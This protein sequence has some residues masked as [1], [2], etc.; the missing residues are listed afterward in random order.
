MEIDTYNEIMGYMPRERTLF[1]YCRDRYALQLL[2]YA[3]GG[4]A[5][6]GELR[7]GPF[8]SLLEKPAVRRLLA[9]RGDGW[10]DR[11]TLAAAWPEPG[12]TF[13]LT[14]GRWGGDSRRWQQTSRPGYNLVLRLNF[15][16]GHDRRYRTLVNPERWHPFR[17]YCHPMLMPGER[18]YMRETLAW[19]RIDLDLDRGEALIEEIQSD[20]VR[21]AARMAAR[22]DGGAQLPRRWLWQPDP[23]QVREYVAQVLAPYGAIW[24]QAMLSAA[25]GFIREELGLSRIWYHSWEG[26]CALKRISPE[27]APPRSLYTQLPQR[28]CFRETAQAPGF[29]TAARCYRRAE[30]QAGG[31]RWYR[32]NL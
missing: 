26:G 9:G 21:R 31:I 17:V 23:E 15:N 28:F 12:E 3:A 29:L 13:L 25:I 5:R 24:D 1:H 10:L 7:Q 22:I 16:A 2:S 20:W 18:P 4:G 11:A 19:A 6:V 30:R 8:A 32:L 14:L 27:Q